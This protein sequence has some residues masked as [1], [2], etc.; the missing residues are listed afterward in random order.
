MA[1]DSSFHTPAPLLGIAA[2]IAVLAAIF[3]PY[4]I[5][6]T[7]A[8][9]GLT[10]YYTSGLAGV[11]GA[12]GFALVTLI[13]FAAGYY[14]RTEP[15]TVAAATT[16]LGVF[17]VLLTLLWAL[18]VPVDVLGSL[19]TVESAFGAT[20]MENHRWIVLLCSLG[21]PVSGVWYARAL[22]LF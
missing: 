19:T 13:A 1:E 5:L 3:A 21:V 22:K 16:A 2:D 7:N 14:Q 20:L 12:A 9:S 18:A 4:L 17:M 10:V 6:P 11:F 15:V 8:A